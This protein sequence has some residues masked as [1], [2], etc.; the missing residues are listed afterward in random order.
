MSLDSG[1]SEIASRDDSNSDSSHIRIV[2]LGEDAGVELRTI[3]SGDLVAKCKGVT[4]QPGRGRRKGYYGRTLLTLRR[5]KRN[6]DHRAPGS[7]FVESIVRHDHH[8]PVSLLLG[9]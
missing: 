4:G 9:A 1:V 7:G 2:Q 5:R 3:Q 6:Y 8:R